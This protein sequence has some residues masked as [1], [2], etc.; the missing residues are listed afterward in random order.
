MFLKFQYQKLPFI[1]QPNKAWISRP[2]LTITILG[3]GKQTKPFYALL[4]SGADTVLLPAE[5]AVEIGIADYK[6]GRHEPVAGIIGKA[7]SY[8]HDAEIQVSGDTRKTSVEIGF[9][10]KL[11]IPLLGR[12]FFGCFNSVVF[13]EAKHTFELRR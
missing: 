1:G 13:K 6:S 4:D 8:Y 2:Y 7:D 12:T 3:N 5:L 9:M 10:E 11:T